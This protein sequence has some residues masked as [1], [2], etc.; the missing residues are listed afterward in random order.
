MSEFKKAGTTT[1]RVMSL[2]PAQLGRYKR[3]ANRRINAF[4]YHRYVITFQ[5]KGYNPQFPK[6]DWKR[7]RDIKK[8]PILFKTYD[9]AKKYFDAHGFRNVEGHKLSGSIEKIVLRRKW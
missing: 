5:S 8:V 6:G 1:V 9:D 7:Y 3:N 4:L 2:K